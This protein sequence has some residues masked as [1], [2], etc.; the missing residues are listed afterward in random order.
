M[1]FIRFMVSSSSSACSSMSSIRAFWNFIVCI[2]PA[3]CMLSWNGIEVCSIAVPSG[4]V[5][6]CT[7]EMP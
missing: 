3:F 2:C 6:A 7:R 1:R 5:I 4:R